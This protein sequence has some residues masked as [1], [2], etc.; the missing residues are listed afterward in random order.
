MKQAILITGTNQGIGLEFAK[1]YKEKGY[2]VYA[3]CRKA[4]DELKALSVNVI[5]GIELTSDDSLKKLQESL[6]GIKLDVFLH[7]AGIFL[8]ETLD[9]M[10]F[11]QIT[12]QYEVNTLAP[13]KTAM[14]LRANLQ[15][16]SKIAFVTSRMGSISDNTSGSYYGYR[17][18]KAGLN[19]FAKSLAVDLKT[20]GIPVILLHPGYVQ[21]NM[22]NYNGDI[23]PDVSA[24][25]L[26]A[27]IDE[28][29]INSTGSFMH[30]NGE[31][32]PW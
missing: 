21:T 13:L 19:A 2:E 24:K 20:D 7:N 29:T 32:L 22:T 10:D 28:L 14:A 30:T 11:S 18:S 16:G 1:Q 25:G 8:N 9:S 3:T 27:R 4:S 31:E 17:M 5:E 23:T 12:K 15:S 26:I 6:A